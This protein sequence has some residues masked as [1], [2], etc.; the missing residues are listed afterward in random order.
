VIRTAL[1]DWRGAKAVDGT[2]VRVPRLVARGVTIREK[3]R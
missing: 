3:I 2:E 1:T